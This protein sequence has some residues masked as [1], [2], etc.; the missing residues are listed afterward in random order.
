VGA[1]FPAILGALV[2][3]PVYFIGRELFNRNVGLLSASLIAVLPGQFLLRSLLGFTDH[4]IAEV[5]F[6]TT[7]ALFLILAIKRVR[8]KET[9]FSHMRRKEWGRLR[10]PVIYALLAGIALGIYI[11]SW[12]GALLFVSILFAY[13]IVQ[14]VIDHLRGKSTDYLCIIG[15]P[16]FLITLIIVVPFLDSLGNGALVIASLAIGLFAFPILSG[17]S[18]LMAHRNMKRAYYPLVLVVLGLVGMALLYVIDPS[19]YHTLLSRLQQVFTPSETAQTIGEVRSVLSLEGFALT[20]RF[21]GTN[22]FIALIALGL[23]IYTGIKQRSL[24]RTLTFLIIWTLIML[25]A[26]LGQN[27]FA[28]YFAVNVALLTGFLCWRVLEWSWSYM[29]E[30]LPEQES[31]TSKMLPE[32]EIEKV[33]TTPSVRQ[34][35]VTTHS[36]R[37]VALTIIQRYIYS[38]SWRD[39]VEIAREER[40]KRRQMP[41]EQKREARRSFKSHFRA[42]QG[43]TV[44]AMIVFVIAFTPNI[45]LASQMEYREPPGPGKAWYSSLVWMRDNTP[46]PFGDPEFYYELYDRPPAGERYAYPESAYGVMNFWDTGHWITRIA[47]RIPNANPF[48]RGTGETSRFFISQNESLANEVLDELDSKYVIIDYELPTIE[49]LDVSVW[50]GEDPSRFFE[51]YYTN[52]EEGVSRIQIYYYPEYYRSMTSRLYNFGGQAV[53]VHNSTFVISYDEATS[54]GITQRQITSTRSFTTYEEAQTYVEGQTDPNYRIVGMDPFTSPVPL[55]ELEHYQMVH[56][57]DPEVPT[58]KKADLIPYVKI[59]EYLP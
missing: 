16:I 1:Y 14:Y 41:E 43:V 6:S 36:V 23:I 2:T 59:F 28:Y 11:I 5:L 47:R 30:A 33:D 40:K 17:I 38:P 12:T 18:R 15:V 42:W 19:L 29:R 56:Q 37:Q 35:A 54:L 51:P 22:F 49:F 13:M 55:Q 9:S 50:A 53:V 48:Q 7:A 34:V 32:R 52:P 3:V 27:R 46:D 45:L 21:F 10:K 44:T 39:G 4:H 24:Q 25:L 57:S 31:S 26:M 58:R 20:I 8:E